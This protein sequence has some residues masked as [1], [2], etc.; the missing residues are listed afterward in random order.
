MGIFAGGEP[1]LKSFT[2][3]TKQI[4]VVKEFGYGYSVFCWEYTSNIFRKAIY[5]FRS[6]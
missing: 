2:E 5:A 3:I 6:V 1:Q 4:E